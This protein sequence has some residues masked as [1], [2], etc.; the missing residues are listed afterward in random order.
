MFNSWL[1]ESQDNLPLTWWKQHP[2]YLAAIIALVGAA[3]MVLTAVLGYELMGHLVF[4][5]E[6]AFRQL[7]LWTP[8]T[9]IFVNPPSIWTLVGCLLLWN[10]GEAVE[11]HLGR[12]AFVRLLLLLLLVA[13]LLVTLIAL[14][15]GRG[16]ACMGIMQLEFGI[17]IAFATL[18]PR[19]KLSVIILT[20]D[21]W[22]LAAVFV[23]LNALGSLANRDW[24]SLM[25]LAANVGTAYVFI[26]FETGALKLP[27]LP[28]RSPQAKKAAKKSSTPTVDDILDKISHQGMQ[29]LTAEERRILDKASEE[30]KRRAG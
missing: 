26:R 21:A 5:Y 19:A 4:T 30:M 3:S 10:F 17:F 7:H 16:F 20:I 6:S 25:L 27:S 28:K 11:R 8:L 18:Y 29:S 12:R 23:G 9:Y 22:V 13:P 14:A 24:S 15:G 2:V 1:P